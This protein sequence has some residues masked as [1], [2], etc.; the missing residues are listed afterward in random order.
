MNEERR[1]RVVEKELGDWRE[2]RAL[3]ERLEA[4]EGDIPED[5]ESDSEDEA[6]EESPNGERT[7]W[8]PKHA[9]HW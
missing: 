6:T 2:E 4:E 1:G 5:E 9:Q 3:E 7:A 8:L